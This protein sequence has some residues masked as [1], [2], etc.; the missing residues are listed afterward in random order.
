MTHTRRSFIK[1][2]SLAAAGLGLTSLISSEAIAKAKKLISA[3]DKIRI[4]VIG[5]NG[6]GWADLTAMMRIPETQVVALC[7]V[8][9]NVLNWRKF[10]LAKSGTP[11]QTYGDYRKMLDNKDIDVIIIGTPDHWHC[12]QMTDACAAGK[13]VYVEKPVG[14]SIEECNAMVSA[15]V[16]YNKAVQAGREAFL[17]GRMPKKLYSASPSSPTT[18][19]ISAAGKTA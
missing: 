9:E 15:Q 12:L 7:D 1:S 4:G 11:V 5:I 14:N 19:M 3:N 17:A 13:D 18:G 16:R 6:M 10:E 2:S 8:D